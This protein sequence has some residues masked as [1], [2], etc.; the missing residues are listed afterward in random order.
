[1]EK[2]HHRITYNLSLKVQIW[3]LF[4]TITT[5]INFGIIIF[6]SITASESAT[7][8]IP[9]KLE[10]EYGPTPGQKLDILGTDLPNGKQ[11]MFMVEIETRL[12]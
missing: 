4:A 12:G 9:H 7:N 6:V 1:M 2:K 10:I 11:K 5:K 3:F 8:K